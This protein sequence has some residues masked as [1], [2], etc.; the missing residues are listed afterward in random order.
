MAQDTLACRLDHK[1]ESHTA[2]CM[3]ECKI[4]FR[5][6]RQLQLLVLLAQMLLELLQVLHLQVESLLG[7]QR[8]LLLPELLF[9]LLLLELF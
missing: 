4:R 1:I 9:Q 7:Q 5:V 6:L 3:W 2:M 8:E